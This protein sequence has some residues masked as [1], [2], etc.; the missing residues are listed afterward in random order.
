MPRKISQKNMEEAVVELDKVREE[1]MKRPGV[2]AL[3]VG[4]EFKGGKMT[5]QLAIRVHVRRK[6]PVEALPANEVFPDKL[7][8]F[9][10]DVIEAVYGLES[11]GTA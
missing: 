5:D 8:R 7:G 10:V 6:L 9:P 1:W 4:Y 11:L 2:T 3:D